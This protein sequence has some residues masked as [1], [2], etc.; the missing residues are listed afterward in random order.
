MNKKG[1]L[2][3]AMLETPKVST[4]KKP[5]ASKIKKQDQQ[6]HTISTRPPSR[7]GKKNISVWVDPD[8]I[9]QLKQIAIAEDKTSQELVCEAINGLFVKYHKAQIA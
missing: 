6:K 3:K 7:Q 9:K 8:V 5:K 1:S 4:R 2:A